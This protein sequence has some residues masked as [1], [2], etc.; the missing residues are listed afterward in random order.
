MIWRAQRR[1]TVARMRGDA[2]AAFNLGRLLS[3]HGDLAGA[4]AAYH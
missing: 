3:E 2:L 4:E 1:P